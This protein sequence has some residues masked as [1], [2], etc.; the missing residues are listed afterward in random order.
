MTGLNPSSKGG[1]AIEVKTAG[2][3]HAAVMRAGTFEGRLGRPCE[4]ALFHGKEG[5]GGDDLIDSARAGGKAL[6]PQ[7][8]LDGNLIIRRCG[9]ILHEQITK[10]RGRRQHGEQRAAVGWPR[11]I[12]YL[13]GACCLQSV[14]SRDDGHNDEDFGRVN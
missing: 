12:A 9:V 1:F 3:T 7:R 8:W 13:L 10:A 5:E 14:P 4:G 11:A 2:P 6:L